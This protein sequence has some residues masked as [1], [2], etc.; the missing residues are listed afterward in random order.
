M[1][2]VELYAINYNIMLDFYTKTCYNYNMG[3]QHVRQRT[4]KIKGTV[5][6]YEDYPY[7]DADKQQTRHKRVYIGKKDDSGIFIPNKTWLNRSQTGTGS[8]PQD[9]PAIARRTYFGVT[10]LLDSIA[11]R[12]SIDQDLRACFPRDHEKIR[13]LASYLVCESESPMYRFGRWAHTHWHPYG[14]PLTSQRI[15]ELFAGIDHQACMRFFA[16]QRRRYSEQEHLAY[17]ITSISSYSELIRHVRYGKNK[18]A[19]PLPQINLALIFGQSSMMPVYYRRLPGNVTDVTTIRKLL[20]DLDEMDFGRVKLVLD[21][22]FYSAKNIDALYL[23]RCKFILGARKST[24][25]VRRHL[26]RYRNKVTDFTCYD[27]ELGLHYLSLTDKWPYQEY[28]NEG[29][30]VAGSER[31][32]Y[33][34]IYYNGGQAES[35]KA[36]FFRQLSQVKAALLEGGCSEQQQVMAEKFFE[37][38]TTPVRGTRIEYRE[39]AIREHTRN[40]GYFVLLSNQIKDP[41]QALWVYRNKDLVEKSFGNLKNRLNM[42]RPMVSSEESLDGKLFVQ[43][44]ALMLVSWIHKVMKEHGLYKTWTM[45][46]LLDE[47]DI[48]ERYNVEGKRPHYGEVTGKQRKI[49]ESF[50][51]TAPDML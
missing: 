2:N 43:F 49:Y 33:V 12:T 13:S 34:H 27:P 48:I 24:L 26:D 36:A 7:W 32:I 40:F 18:N 35:E 20:R 10:W 46:E 45:Q 41:R 16:K 51:F 11:K 50:G 38:S 25:F 22:G 21:R 5:Y 37:V 8:E 23:H 47:L 19:E 39:Q 1:Y 6:V 17:D 9:R 29:N 30:V 42:R 14:E 15:S 4:Q 28:D 31:R 3:I 44:I